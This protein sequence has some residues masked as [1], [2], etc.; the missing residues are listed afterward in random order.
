MFEETYALQS[1]MLEKLY[2]HMR[3]CK[4]KD[5]FKTPFLTLQKTIKMIEDYKLAYET[6]WVLLA[7]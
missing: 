1:I 6:F 7:N 3:L 4:N 2:I 5:E